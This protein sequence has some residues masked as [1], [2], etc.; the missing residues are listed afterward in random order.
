MEGGG[1]GLIEGSLPVV[2]LMHFALGIFIFV[3][4]EGREVV[5]RVSLMFFMALA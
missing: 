2:V 4:G 5:V 1:E 3:D